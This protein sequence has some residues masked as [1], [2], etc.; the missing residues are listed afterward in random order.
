MSKLN[1]AQVFQNNT[2]LSNTDCRIASGLSQGEWSKLI[3]GKAVITPRT[4]HFFIILESLPT[5]VLDGHIR[6]IKNASV[7]K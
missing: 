1:A 3:N 4:N 2:G 7:A 5:A 6:R